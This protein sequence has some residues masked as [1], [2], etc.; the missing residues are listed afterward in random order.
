MLHEQFFAIPG[1]AEMQTDSVKSILFFPLNFALFFTLIFLGS[2]FK[3][4][5][6]FI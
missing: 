5:Y 3:L 4:L 1:C 6:A 2:L